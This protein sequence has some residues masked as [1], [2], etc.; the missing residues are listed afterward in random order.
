MDY[1][2]YR[3][4]TEHPYQYFCVINKDSKN[5]II[6]EGSVLPFTT[7]KLKLEEFNL[8]DVSHFSEENR[9]SME[10]YVNN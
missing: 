9:Q 8:N 2:V 3:E 10:K 4:F 6:G 1:R 7:K 5:I